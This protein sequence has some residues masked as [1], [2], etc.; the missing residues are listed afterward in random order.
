MV[1]SMLCDIVQDKGPLRC[2]GLVCVLLYIQGICQY[3][4]VCV[5]VL[6]ILP[7]SIYIL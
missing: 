3:Q 2:D 6:S 4:S 5:C 1:H 7:I